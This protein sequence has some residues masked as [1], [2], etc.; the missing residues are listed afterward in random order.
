MDPEPR[1]AAQLVVDGAD[2][3]ISDL[4]KQRA[5]GRE[6]RSP[7]HYRHSSLKRTWN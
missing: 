5:L 6:A 2:V 4:V 1:M 3:Q 7:A